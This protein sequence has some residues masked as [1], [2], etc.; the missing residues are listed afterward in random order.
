[1][2]KYDCEVKNAKGEI[3]KTQLTADSLQKLSAALSDKGF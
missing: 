2:P 1:M 3:L